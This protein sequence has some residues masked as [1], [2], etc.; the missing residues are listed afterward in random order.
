MVFCTHSPSIAY[1]NIQISRVLGIIIYQYLRREQAKLAIPSDKYEEAWNEVFHKRET[2]NILGLSNFFSRLIIFAIFIGLSSLGFLLRLSAIGWFFVFFGIFI[3]GFAAVHVTIGITFISSMDLDDSFSY[4]LL[5]IVTIA[6]YGALLFQEEADDSNS[7]TV[8]QHLF[9][10]N[11]NVFVDTLAAYT[12][13]I[14]FISIFLVVLVDG[15][16]FWQIQKKKKN[17]GKYLFQRN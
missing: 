5:F 11:K 7:S 13:P 12:L 17:K 15:Y 14:M 1:A 16:F 9:I 3:V 10:H 4:L 6:F 8:I 2:Q